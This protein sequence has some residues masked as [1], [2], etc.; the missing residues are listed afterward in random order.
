MADPLLLS[1]VHGWSSM[2]K[3][4]IHMSMKS[5]PS[6]QTCAVTSNG[7][8]MALLFIPDYAWKI[9]LSYCLCHG[10]II[11]ANQLVDLD[12]SFGTQW[13][14]AHLL[15]DRLTDG[16]LWLCSSLVQSGDSCQ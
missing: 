4:R 7:L 9:Y 2:P 11:Q 14:A 8:A 16:D 12:E 5:F 6:P 1:V 10:S 15:H 3:Q 13:Y